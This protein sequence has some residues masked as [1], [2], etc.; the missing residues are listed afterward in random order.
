MT[1]H[2]EKAAAAASAGASLGRGACIDEPAQAG[3]LYRAE[4]WGP[5]EERRAEYVRL[6]D[7]IRSF[8]NSPLR[9]ALLGWYAR[10]VLLP[11]LQEIP[12]KLKWADGFTNLVTTE[13]KNAALTHFLKGSSYTASQ[14]LG[15][16]EDTGYSAVAA[17]NTAA[18]ITANG[19]GSPAN[20]WNEAPSA[21]CASRGTPSF[22]TASS[23]SLA[24]SSSVS[25][26]ILATDTI[27]GAFLLCR[28]AGGTAPSTT[29]GNT[30][31]ALYSAG[32]FSGGDRS[33]ANGD[34]LNVSYTASL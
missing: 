27:K 8:T 20:G 5:A 15:L 4:C 24:T 33:V 6:R 28:S 12:L 7:R 11:R 29:V 10:R 9:R 2:T 17:G 23:G 31:G 16:I 30:S 25:F 19:S 18:N 14:V 26:S 3:G 21:T 13:G 22:G 34:T 1:R 32:L